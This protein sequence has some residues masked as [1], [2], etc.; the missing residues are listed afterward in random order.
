MANISLKGTPVTTSGTIPD[1]G[2]TA[3][4][5]TLVNQDLASVGLTDYAGKKKVLNIFPSVDTPVCA[6]SI[7]AFTQKAAANDNTVVLHIS[8]D[9]PFAAKRFCGA[10]GVENAHTLSTFRGNFADDYGLKITDGPLAG[11]CSRVVLVLDENNKVL[12]GEQ[13]PAI[14]NEP[15]YDD[16]LKALS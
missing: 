13:V 14:E 5:F 4:E 7:K 11:L 10:E 9:L 6:L 12:Y 3:P 16:A 1:N 8:A 2:S 15:N